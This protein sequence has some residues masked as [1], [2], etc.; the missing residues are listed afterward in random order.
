MME[1]YG[2]QVNSHTNK[3]SLFQT[4]PKTPR[5]KKAVPREER[6]ALSQPRWNGLWKNCVSSGLQSTNRR[7]MGVSERYWLIPFSSTS[8]GV[9]LFKASARGFYQSKC[10][11][12]SKTLGVYPAGPVDQRL[13]AACFGANSVESA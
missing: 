6:D 11:A 8:G 12:K 3:A 13:A 10:T 4:A 1:R 9:N 7:P 5:D 2:R